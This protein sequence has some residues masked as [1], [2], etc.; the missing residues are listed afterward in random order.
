[1]PITNVT[2][3]CRFNKDNLVKQSGGY[4]SFYPP[5]GQPIFI[6]RFKYLKRNMGPFMTFLR[7]N[8]TVEEYMERMDAG[9]TPL[10]I[11]KSKGYIA[12]HIKAQMKKAG[13]PVTQ[14]GHD[15]W[16]AAEM[17]KSELALELWRLNN[18]VKEI[19]QG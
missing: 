5:Q 12:A 13:Y 11:V 4:I 3:L 2:H 16:W 17:K 1:M 14:A 15:E 8:F 18:P 9:E 10:D 19:Y 7:K 6:A